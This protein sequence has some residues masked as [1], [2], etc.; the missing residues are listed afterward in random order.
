MRCLVDHVVVHV[1]QRSEHVDVTIH[2]HGGFTSQHQVV[3]PVGC[4]TQ[5]RDY[6]LLITRIKTL[7]QEGKT[8]PAIAERLNA[9]GF[10]PDHAG[11]VY[12]RWAPWPP[13]WNDWGWWANVIATTCLAPTSG[14]SVTWRSS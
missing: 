11:V 12:S 5:L 14:G 7:Y 4:Y 6:D 13:S 3:R 1:E 9:E 2:W 10:C 8:V